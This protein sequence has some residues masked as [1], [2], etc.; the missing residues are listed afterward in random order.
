MKMT[1]PWILIINNQ[2]AV[3]DPVFIHRTNPPRFCVNISPAFAEEI[4]N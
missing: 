1:S 3:H 2:D 4:A